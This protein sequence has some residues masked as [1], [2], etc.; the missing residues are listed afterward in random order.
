VS[1]FPRIGKGQRECQQDVGDIRVITSVPYS[2]SSNG[3]AGTHV[4]HLEC[5]G[6][7]FVLVTEENRAKL[8][9]WSQSNSV[10]VT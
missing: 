4:E 8:S 2:P 1:P 9:K 5:S 3:I 10:H 6:T 7:P